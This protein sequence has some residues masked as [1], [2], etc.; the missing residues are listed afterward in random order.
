MEESIALE[1]A[2]DPVE[3]ALRCWPGVAEDAHR[4]LGIIQDIEDRQAERD[5]GRLAIAAGP[6]IEITVGGGLNLSDTIEQPLV[7]HVLA[8]ADEPQEKEQIALG[9][10]AYSRQPLLL[11]ARIENLQERRV[12][13]KAR[14]ERK[15]GRRSHPEA[16]LSS[17][18]GSSG[19]TFDG[20]ANAAQAFRP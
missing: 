7:P 10:D 20:V 2:L 11:V 14:R 18:F 5:D 19:T 9:Q 8:L 13:L 17:F 6:Q 12:L 4:D 15:V 3:E 16:S 1:L